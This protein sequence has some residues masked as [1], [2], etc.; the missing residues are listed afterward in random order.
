MI[1]S[2]F[3]VAHLICI[4]M[5][6]DQS[7]THRWTSQGDRCEMRRL[8]PVFRDVKNLGRDGKK[9]TV[10]IPLRV[11]LGKQP[12]KSTEENSQDTNSPVEQDLLTISTRR[13]SQLNSKIVF[14]V[15]L[16][17]GK[18][19]GKSCWI[20]TLKNSIFQTIVTVWTVERVSLQHDVNT[21]AL[22]STSVLNV[23]ELYVSIETS[24]MYLSNG[25]CVWIFWG[26][27]YS[28]YF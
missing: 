26:R 3:P 16:Q 4:N 27:L 6:F 12:H 28:S 20:R 15:S 2:V 9:T 14:W 18:R 10:S 11:D 24:F 5:F 8:K 23:H 21:V 7:I 19:Y 13:N 17:S 1:I 22:A 25:R